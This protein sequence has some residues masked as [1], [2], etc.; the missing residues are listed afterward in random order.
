MPPPPSKQPGK[1][2]TATAPV[3]A[4]AAAAAGALVNQALYIA[5]LGTSG[6]GMPH[7][8]VAVVGKLQCS[9]L[10]LPCRCVSS[11]YK[12]HACWQK[13]HL[14]IEERRGAGFHLPPVGIC[15]AYTFPR[16]YLQSYTT[17]LPCLT[18]SGNLLCV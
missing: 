13:P 5:L 4:S 16:T 1:A 7:V 17:G 12:V 3:K 9:L 18:A 2:P 6:L 10:W 8:F 14:A 15:L 11:G